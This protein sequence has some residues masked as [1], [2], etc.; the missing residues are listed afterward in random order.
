MAWFVRGA[1]CLENGITT[2]RISQIGCTVLYNCSSCHVMSINVTIIYHIHKCTVLAFRIYMCT[3][4]RRPTNTLAVD[5]VRAIYPH[6]GVPI[7]GAQCVN[8]LIQHMQLDIYINY[9]ISYGLKPFI[10]ILDVLNSK[11]CP[12][13]FI[14][15]IH[16]QSDFLKPRC[17]VLETNS[18]FQIPSPL[19]DWNMNHPLEEPMALV[20]LLH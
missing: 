6:L 19:Y 15:G 17:Q 5:I 18:G 20:E 13:V 7:Q 3:L 1:W 12:K 8:M 4:T 10:R 14:F 9:M 2:A 11:F 16:G